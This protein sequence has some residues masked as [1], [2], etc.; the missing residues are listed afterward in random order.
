MFLCLWEGEEEED[1]EEKPWEDKSGQQTD[2]YSGL[3][4][5]DP[6]L[7]LLDAA[8]L[9]LGSHYVL[10]LHGLPESHSDL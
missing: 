6:L 5:C 7:L 4:C 2:A 3:T 9:S 10:V 1:E 8:M